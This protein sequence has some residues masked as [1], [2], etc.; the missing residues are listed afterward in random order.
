LPEE[1]ELV[2]DGPAFG[3]PAPDIRTMLIAAR[4]IWRPVAGMPRNGRAWVPQMVYRSASLSPSARM[5]SM[6][7]RASGNACLSSARSRV[8]PA[9]DGE[10]TGV[11]APR[12]PV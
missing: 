1:A 10:T 2:G 12:A 7:N 4:W 6:V 3:D 5:S 9:R 8:N 11:I